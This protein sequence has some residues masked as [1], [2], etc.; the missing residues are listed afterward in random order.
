MSDELT[1][2]LTAGLVATATGL[3]GPF[4]VLRRVALM[5]DAVS[6]AVLPGIVVVFL[7]LGTRAPLPVVLGASV[8][9]VICVLGVDALRGSGLVASDAAIALVFP[10]LFSLGVLG[11]SR[12][13]ANVHLDLDSTIY[14]E[15]A[16]VPFRTVTVGGLEIARS[17]LALAGVC[18]V[19][20]ALV[21]LLWK[22]FKVSTFDPEFSRTVGIAPTTLSRLLLV[23]VAVTAV[24]AFEPVGAI[25]VVT[26]VIVPATTA[27]L[28]TDSLWLMVAVAVVVGWISAL[29]GYA[30]AR[31]LDASIPG[32]MGLAATAAF[33]LVLLAAPRYGLLVGALRPGRSRDRAGRRPVT[34]LGAPDNGC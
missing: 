20:L 8:F 10:V 26:M 17:L 23:A 3:L 12:Y 18:L 4:L 30:G 6:H 31:G 16:F 32:S 28:L 5:A 22:E 27:Y 9:A 21:L 7:L 1:I 33:V 19:N 15:I 2:L 11:V 29:I 34:G 13:A 25:L 24:V 14:G